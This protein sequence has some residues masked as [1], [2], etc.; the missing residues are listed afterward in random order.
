[1][2]DIDDRESRGPDHG[3]KDAV[4]RQSITVS[5]LEDVRPEAW[6]R[7]ADE[8]RDLATAAVK[9]REHV[10]NVL[11][12]LPFVWQSESALSARVQLMAMHEELT[13]A[14]HESKAAATT[15][16]A[17]K[18]GFK[19]ATTWLDEAKEMAKQNHLTLNDD[20]SVT[21]PDRNYPPNDPDSAGAARQDQEEAESL[22]TRAAAALGYAAD[23]NEHVDYEIERIKK[24]VKY[25]VLDDLT[26]R[27]I[28]GDAQGANRL[29]RVL[30]GRGGVVLP[31]PAL[32][33]GSGDYKSRE[34]TEEDQGIKNRM[35]LFAGWSP[36]V[37]GGPIA[38]K[39]MMHFLGNSGDPMDIDVDAMLNDLPD[40]QRN[41]ERQ[42]AEN[43][44][45]WKAQAL[46]EFERT[47]KPVSMVQQ[48]GWQGWE[49]EK[50]SD[51]YHAMGSYHYNTVAQVEVVPGPDGEPKATIRYQTHVHDRYNWDK[52][53]ETPVPALGNV[54]DADLARLHR[55]GLA[56]EFDMSGQSEV[57]TWK[58]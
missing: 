30:S 8:W 18:N 48:T 10:Q 39:H 31:P 24:A 21:I 56:R 13:I 23:V 40:M 26:K 36:A 34:P 16:S 28:K 14:K 57:R 5:E 51:W 33:E 55:A 17:A 38:S 27:S 4:Q 3:H 42:L 52:G 29:D 58:G 37:L 9:A 43:A 6:D 12:K 7:A 49:A 15:L 2:A 22:R 54:S 20:G 44:D 11:H 1:M 46:A 41:S 53:K 45:S 25:S 35:G 32:D 50:D 19:L 47:G